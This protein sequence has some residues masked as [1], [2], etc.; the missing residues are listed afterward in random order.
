M[1]KCVYIVEDHDEVREGYILFFEMIGGLDVCGAV[2]TA[3]QALEEIPGLAPDMVIIDISLPG[4]NGLSLVESLRS[5]SPGIRLLVV[6]GHHESQYT[7]PA[8]QA[9]ADGFV[10]KGDADVILEAVERVLS[11]GQFFPS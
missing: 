11:G 2:A 10:R 3:E 6:S 8:R 4:M 1:N 7:E 5:T 9:G